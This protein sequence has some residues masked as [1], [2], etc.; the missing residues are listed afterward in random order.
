MPS[1]K[2]HLMPRIEK[3]NYIVGIV[4]CLRAARRKLAKLPVFALES[5]KDMNMISP[6]RLYQLQ[7]KSQ[8]RSD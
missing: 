5:D 3:S 1:A 2:L 4:T 8:Q 7:S 6:Q